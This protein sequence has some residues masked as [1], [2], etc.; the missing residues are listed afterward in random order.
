MKQG[1]MLLALG[2]ALALTGTPLAAQPAAKSANAP[3][4][5]AS[6][7]EGPAPKSRNAVRQFT[8]YVTSLDRTSLTVEKR[9]KNPRSMVFTKD[10]AL[11]LSAAVDK[12]ARV[13]VYYRDEDGHA[14]AQRVVAKV[15]TPRAPK[16][17]QDPPVRKSSRKGR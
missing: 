7:A 17:S 2:A 8:G 1:R 9:G 15:P 12:D 11:T 10:A 16:A 13:T 4:A 14:V 3:A 5:D 6:Q